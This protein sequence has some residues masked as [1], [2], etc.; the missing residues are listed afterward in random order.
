MQVF[1]VWEG[2]DMIYTAVFEW[3]EGK[4]PRVGKGDAWKGGEYVRALDVPNADFAQK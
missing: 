3:P 1:V 4:E 2:V